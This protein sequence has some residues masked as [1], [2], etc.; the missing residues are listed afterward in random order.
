MSSLFEFMTAMLKHGALCAAA[1]GLVGGAAVM[2]PA[3][4][5][6]IQRVVSPGGVEAWLVTERTVPLVA[7]TFAFRGGSAQDPDGK[8]GLAQMVSSL[9]DEGAGELDDDAFQRRMED[10]AVRL[11]FNATRDNLMGELRTLS[12]NRDEGFELLRLAVNAPRFDEAP[13]E[14]IRAQL[15]ARL[16]ARLEDPEDM[17][18]R[19]WSGAARK[20]HGCGAE[21]AALQECSHAFEQARQRRLLTHDRPCAAWASVVFSR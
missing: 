2:A 17:A 19:A 21:R 16:R 5:T 4:A 6:E 9:L 15:L 7:M 12:R 13:V 1:V 18:S 10:A 20:A 8:E 3:S 11:T 14:R